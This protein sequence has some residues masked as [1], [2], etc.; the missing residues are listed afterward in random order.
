M[1]VFIVHTR[2]SKSRLPNL[3]WTIKTTI[4]QTLKAWKKKKIKK[5]QHPTSQINSVTPYYIYSVSMWVNKVTRQS[6]TLT[7][8]PTCP[9]RQAE[10]NSTCPVPFFGCMNFSL[11]AP[12]KSKAPKTNKL[13][14]TTV[15]LSF[16]PGLEIYAFHCGNLLLLFH[17]PELLLLSGFRLLSL[18]GS[19]LLAIMLFSLRD[20]EWATFFQ[21]H[22]HHTVSKQSIRLFM[23]SV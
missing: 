5:S 2:F 9:V 7:L 13:Q 16:I 22:V 17:C 14:S 12:T 18:F 10:E 11:H 23:L 21:L 19:D 6:L 20:W 4:M 8:F 15:V 1:V 3:V